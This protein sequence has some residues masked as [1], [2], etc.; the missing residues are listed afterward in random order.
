MAHQLNIQINLQ[1]T[2]YDLIST[3]DC[4]NNYYKG[5]SGFYP[6]NISACYKNIIIDKDSYP[7]YY[8]V[9]HD[10]INSI[11]PYKINEGFTATIPSEIN[12]TDTD[13]SVLAQYNT[14]ND[15]RVIVENKISEM[16]SKYDDI[17]LQ[18]NNSM[19]STFLITTL[20]TSVLY[21]LFMKII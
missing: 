9:D 10:S 17:A 19:Y 5:S 21:F 14:M 12:D 16:E 11:R 18:K 2:K 15:E 13:T 1:K 7:E 3:K 20:G 8:F 6:A 4:T